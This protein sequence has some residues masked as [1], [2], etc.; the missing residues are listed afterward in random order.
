MKR[1][2]VLLPLVAVALLAP[3]VEA[4]SPRGHRLVGELA[5]RQLHP[6]TARAVDE[7]LEGEPEPT[8]GGVA[9]WADAL[10][11]AEPERFAATSRWHYVKTQPGSCTIDRA[12]D[13]P[14]DACVVGAIEAQSRILADASRPREERRDALKFLVH[15]VGDVHQPMHAGHRDDQGGNKVA[16][17]LRTDIPPEAYARDKYRDGVMQTNV[18]AV[19]DYYVLGSFAGTDAQYADRLHAPGWPARLAVLTPAAAWAGESCRLSDRPGLYPADT[20]VDAAYLDA[21]RPLAEQRVRQAAF[22]LAWLLDTLLAR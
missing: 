18:H 1:L 8:L 2:S 5:Q 13:C 6:G 7:L 12:K 15:F 19:W 22:R 4:W 20:N 10:R 16:L 9:Y 14:D 3:P 21:F 11:A 17:V